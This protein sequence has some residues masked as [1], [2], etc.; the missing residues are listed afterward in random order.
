MAIYAP[1][2]DL[3]NLALVCFGFKFDNVPSRKHYA[4]YL[5]FIYGLLDRLSLSK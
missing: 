4:S 5:K 2:G 1:Y 3:V